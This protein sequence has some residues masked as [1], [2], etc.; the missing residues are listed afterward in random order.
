MHVIIR[1]IP[2]G[3]PAKAI[4]LIRFSVDILYEKL[5]GS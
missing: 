2:Q 1:K 3:V 5:G 4:F